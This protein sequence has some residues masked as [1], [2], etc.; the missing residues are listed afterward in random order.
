MRNDEQWRPIP[1]Y[2]GMYELSKHGEIRSWKIKGR[3]HGSNE[4]APE[5]HILKP[6]LRKRKNRGY[7][8]EIS[9]WNGVRRTAPLN[10]KNLVRDIW[11]AGPQPGKV[12]KLID[13]DPT[14]VSVYNMR[15]VTKAEINKTKDTSLR[16][17]VAKY[18]RYHTVLEFYRSV[19]DAAFRNHLSVPGMHSRIRRKTVVDGVWFDYAN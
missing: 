14:N 7:V 9:L 4:R 6:A 8:L 2:G 12:V 10:V 15:Y 5:P 18:D 3:W 19:R 17:P 1:G 11:M 13:G 16:R